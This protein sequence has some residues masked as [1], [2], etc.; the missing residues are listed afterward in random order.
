MVL[1]SSE[2]LGTNALQT[3]RNDLYFTTKNMCS[4]D[5]RGKKIKNDS[6][7]HSLEISQTC[8]VISWSKYGGEIHPSCQT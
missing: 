5:L 7:A 6:K 8:R 2:K 3:P 4:D 1:A